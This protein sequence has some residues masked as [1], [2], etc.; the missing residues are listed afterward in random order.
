MSTQGYT[1]IKWERC[2][3]FFINRAIQIFLYFHV[4]RL[5]PQPSYWCNSPRVILLKE[6]EE[7]EDAEKALKSEFIEEEPTGLVSGV[8]IKHLA[9]VQSKMKHVCDISRA[10]GAD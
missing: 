10:D 8:K 2:I 6:K 1:R 7:E 5:L 4:K 9:K 3:F